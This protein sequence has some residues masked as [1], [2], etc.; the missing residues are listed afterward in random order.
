MNLEAIAIMVGRL[1]GEPVS[2]SKLRAAA[3]GVEYRVGK[4]GRKWYDAAAIDKI[5]EAL[6]F[7]PLAFEGKG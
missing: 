6:G 4:G 1:T 2:I 3:A 5:L 7:D